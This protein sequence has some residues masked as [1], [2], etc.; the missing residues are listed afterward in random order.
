MLPNLGILSPYKAETDNKSETSQMLNVVDSFS[1]DALPRV[2]NGS[3]RV[4]LVKLAPVAAARDL[5]TVRRPGKG[6]K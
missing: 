3:F 6:K 5:S 2:E 4:T 1:P